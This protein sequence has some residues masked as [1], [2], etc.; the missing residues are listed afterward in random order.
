MLKAQCSMAKFRIISAAVFGIWALGIGHW[1]LNAQTPRTSW[2]GVF[3]EA[4]AARGTK[5]FTEQCSACHGAEMRG[6]AGAPSLAGPE[7]QFS[8]NKKSAAALFD[9]AK[10][11]MPPGQPG[12]LSDA[13]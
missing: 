7:F 1:A 6:G 8:W 13:Q 12:S 11:F 2:D 5:L 9:Y 10:S 4:Q 3:T